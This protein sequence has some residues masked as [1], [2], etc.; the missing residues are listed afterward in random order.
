MDA[1]YATPYA[2]RM[3]PTPPLPGAVVVLDG[4]DVEGEWERFQPY[5]PLHHAQEICNPMSGA[6]LDGV[7]EALAPASGMRV[8]DVGCG[9]R[10]ATMSARSVSTAHRG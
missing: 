4:T 9:P 5:E 6:E 1:G 10:G 3:M 2:A 7:I 8:V